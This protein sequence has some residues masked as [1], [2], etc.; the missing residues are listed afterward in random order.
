MAAGFALAGRGA[1]RSQLPARDR[2]SRGAPR[3]RARQQVSAG[4]PGPVPTCSPMQVNAYYFSLNRLGSANSISY[5]GPAGI[6]MRVVK[7]AVE[8]GLLRGGMR[9]PA[10]T[11]AWMRPKLRLPSAPAAVP[12]PFASSRG[13]PRCVYQGFAL[14]L[15]E[16]SSYAS[17]PHLNSCLQPGA[18]L[19]DPKSRGA[20][21]FASWPQRSNSRITS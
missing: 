21:A 18:A 9:L 17:H 8:G 1:L 14:P 12:H 7:P 5:S 11:W 19:A 10:A 13:C 2:P 4:S 15:W 16:C 6:L 20:S 3:P